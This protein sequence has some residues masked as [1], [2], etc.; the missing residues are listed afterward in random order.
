[1]AVSPDPVRPPSSAS[2]SAASPFSPGQDSIPTRLSW[3]WRRKWLDRLVYAL[4]GM[5]AWL[6][7][8]IVFW[9][10]VDVVQR[11]LPW[12]TTTFFTEVMPSRLPSRAGFLGAIWGSVFMIL[13]VIPI[14]F[15][16]AIS[17]S[18]YLEEY[19]KPSRWT[20][21]VQ[22]NLSNLAAV[23]S[24]VY[25]MLGVTLFVRALHLG[26]SV[27]S[28]ALTL[29]LMVLP[30]VVVAAQEAIR[31]VPDFLRQASYAM[32]ATHWQTICRVVL[33]RA[34]PGMVT[35][36]LLAVARAFGETAPLILIGVVPFLTRLP[37][38]PLDDFTSMP[39]QI[40]NWI[41]ESQNDFQNLASAGIVVLLAGLF[42]FNII[43]LIIRERSRP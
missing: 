25:G 5:A 43:A 19:A 18:L 42:A 20:R 35:G 4:C 41:S 30:I 13:L 27:L 38:T 39:V 6:G 3:Q 2:S 33:P 21:F 10:L 28:A 17:T 23:P 40:Y 26:T 11:G 24:V 15:F 34:L 9:L 14:A 37:I 16:L 22:L 29:V 7:V 36:M 8:G 32:G 1:M 12:L 31:G